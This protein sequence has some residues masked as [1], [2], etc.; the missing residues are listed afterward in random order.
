MRSGQV[1]A[2]DVV[3]R[4]LP[5]ERPHRDASPLNS[6]TVVSS[7]ATLRCMERCW[8]DLKAGSPMMSFPWALACAEMLAGTDYDL[9]MVTVG[10]PQATAIAPMIKRRGHSVPLEL[11]GVNEHFEPMDFLYES[12]D[13]LKDL[14]NAIAGQQSPLVLKRILAR[15]PAVELLK[16]SFAGRAVI[17]AQEV[18]GS[19]T[20]ALD[21][22]WINPEMR[23]SARRA[24]DIRRSRGIAARMGDL[25]YEVISPSLSD[26]RRLL[27]EAYDVEARSW[28]GRAGSALAQDGMR[29]D[30]YR[31]YAAAACDRG[32]LRLCFMRINGRAVAM[33]IAVEHAGSFW[34]LKIGYDEEFSRCSPGNL[35]ILE[36]IRYAASR[37]IRGYEFLG[38]DE[39]WTRMWTSQVHP[40]TSMRIY[41]ITRKGITALAADSVQRVKRRLNRRKER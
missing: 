25:R 35:L 16:E 4:Q 19:P 8:D 37:G 31:R 27:D 2:A 38:T 12:R 14:V 41:P 13:S 21:Y 34:L 30:F 20:I 33:Q 3:S 40:C 23:L 6:P 17:R 36:T 1:S 18:S 7:M 39:P 26:L 22:S 24:S 10:G 5:L 15:S 9:N 29:G 11:I 28:K 32:T